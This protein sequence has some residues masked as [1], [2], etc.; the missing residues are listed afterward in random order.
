MATP[1]STSAPRDWSTTATATWTSN[2]CRAASDWSAL[3]AA[4]SAGTAQ[5]AICWSRSTSPA[6]APW[7]VIPANY[8]TSPQRLVPNL[9]TGRSAI[10][11]A[12]TEGS[13]GAGF[14]PTGTV[15]FFLCSPA[16]V[17]G[18]GCPAGTQVGVGKVLAAG[19]ATSDTTSATNTPGKYCWRTVY[20]PDAASMG[21]YAPATNTKSTT[22]C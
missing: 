8:R 7:R 3:A 17:I 4:L 14:A 9:L 12:V 19:A 1:R 13:G 6:A 2:S 10:R 5:R 11:D 21:V 22:E 20:A 18:A 16:Q 15:T